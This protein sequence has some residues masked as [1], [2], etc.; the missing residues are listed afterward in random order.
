MIHVIYMSHV[1][2][3]VKTCQYF[4][5]ISKKA[6][7]QIRFHWTNLTNIKKF[8]RWRFWFIFVITKKELD[9]VLEF[10][11][12]F[13]FEV[14]WRFVNAP[15]WCSNADG[16]KCVDTKLYT[17]ISFFKLNFNKFVRH[18]EQKILEG[19]NY[20]KKKIKTTPL[21]VYYLNNT[22]I[23]LLCPTV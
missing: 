13:F 8:K 5:R 22:S 15:F 17:I 2:E 16:L 21:N 14:V 11:W 9:L 3:A 1:I 20:R 12:N 6:Y 7:P 18:I 4:F 10:N 19:T 23:Q